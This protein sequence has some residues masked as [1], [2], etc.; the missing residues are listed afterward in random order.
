MALANDSIDVTP[1]TGATVATH[2]VSSKE[3]QVVMVAGPSG[4]IEGS[5]A[6]Y[7]L[8]IPPIAMGASKLMWDLH[9]GSAS[10]VIKVR[11]VW[12]VPAYDVAVTGVIAVRFDFFRTSSAGTGG[13]AAVY[14]STAVAT[15]PSIV[16]KDTNNAALP[17]GVGARQSP[18]GGAAS[19][20][21]AFHTYHVQEETSAWAGTSQFNNVMPN[22]ERGEQEFTLRPGEGFKCVQGTVAGVAQNVGFLATFTVE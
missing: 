17:S 6:T 16:P 13:T 11:G 1:G 14:N 20:A 2:L 10:N 7:M 8:A 18:T 3:Y 9:N 15:T 5:L 4:H 21:W 12:V 19:A 22:P